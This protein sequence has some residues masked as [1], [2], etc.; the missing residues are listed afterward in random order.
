M[1]KFELIQACI[2]V[3]ITCKNEDPI[4]NEGSRVLTRFSPIISLWEFFSNSQG[5]LTL[6]SLVKSGPNS[7]SLEIFWLSSLPARME[8]IGSKVKALEC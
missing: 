8:Q 6:Q 7:N 1:P 5:Q 2:V 3:L 4:K